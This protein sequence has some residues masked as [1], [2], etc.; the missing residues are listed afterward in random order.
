[1][2]VHSNELDFEESRSIGEIIRKMESP[3]DKLKSFKSILKNSSDIGKQFSVYIGDSVNDLL[4]LLE[5]DVGIVVG[6]SVSLR[7]V[8]AHFGVSFVP[9]FPDLVKKQRQL[10]DVGTTVWKGLSGV[11]Y[12][13]SDW[14]EIHAFILGA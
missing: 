8:G 3:L 5:V 4:C 2:E 7:K 6:S 12:T 9:L 11:L 10:A 14:T 1:M 13:I